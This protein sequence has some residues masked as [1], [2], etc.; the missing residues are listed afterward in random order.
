MDV[1]LGKVESAS[2]FVDDLTALGYNWK[3][4]WEWTLLILKIV[5]EAGFMVNLSNCKFCEPRTVLLGHE[6][7]ATLYQISSKFIAKQVHTLIPRTYQQL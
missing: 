1:L 2:A 4:V 6:V 7:C 5:T 3:D